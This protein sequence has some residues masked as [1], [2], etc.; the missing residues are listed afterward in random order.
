MYFRQIAL[1]F[2][3]EIFE[4]RE[5]ICSRSNGPTNFAGQPFLV[6]AH[7]KGQAGAPPYNP[8]CDSISTA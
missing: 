2:S 8:D 7:R 6:A 4:G 5:L 3:T 1:A